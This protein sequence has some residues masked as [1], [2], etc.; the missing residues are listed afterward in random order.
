MDT[1][2]EFVHLCYSKTSMFSS[3]SLV[4]M[5]LKGFGKRR[6]HWTK[7]RNFVFEWKYSLKGTV[8]LPQNLYINLRSNGFS[9]YIPLPQMQ[10]IFHLLD[11]IFHRAND[12]DFDEV[13][14]TNFSFNTS[15]HFFSE[16]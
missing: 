16:K 2:I 5:V 4:S 3:D 7:Q 11:R 8:L 13:Q 1:K 12:F 6:T 10:T 9:P 14:L 15:C